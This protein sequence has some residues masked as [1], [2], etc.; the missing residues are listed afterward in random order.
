MRSR[1][2]SFVASF[3]S[4]SVRAFFER[5]RDAFDRECSAVV[6]DDAVTRFV[7]G[8]SPEGLASE[9]DETSDVVDLPSLVANATA[10]SSSAWW[11]VAYCVRTSHHLCTTKLMNRP[12]TNAMITPMDAKLPKYAVPK[13]A[14][15]FFECASS[16]PSLVACIKAVHA[17]KQTV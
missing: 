7:D 1:K 5:F 4:L 8:T 3:V 13:M 17:A 14:L 15:K 9:H 2:S 12:N 16:T 11:N 6:F 10:S